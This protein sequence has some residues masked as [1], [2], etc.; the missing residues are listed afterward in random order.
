M[1]VLDSEA[2]ICVPSTSFF[3]V[4]I[5]STTYSH[6]SVSRHTSGMV[7]F[8]MTTRNPGYFYKNIGII[9]FKLDLQWS[10]VIC[11]SELILFTSVSWQILLPV[12]DVVPLS[13]RHLHWN[14]FLQFSVQSRGQFDMAPKFSFS[15]PYCCRATIWFQRQQVNIMPL[16]QCEFFSIIIK[17]I[18][19]LS[20]TILYGTPICREICFPTAFGNFPAQGPVRFLDIICYSSGMTKICSTFK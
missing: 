3:F 7:V 12:E 10:R 1:S 6:G 9:W 13:H 15:L 19:I 18:P 11:S 17:I 5:S 20:W 8:Y 4:L 16:S 2:A 14:L